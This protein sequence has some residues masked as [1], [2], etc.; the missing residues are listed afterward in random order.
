MGVVGKKRVENGVVH[1]PSPARAA[2][3]VTNVLTRT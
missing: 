3:L 2:L 1:Y